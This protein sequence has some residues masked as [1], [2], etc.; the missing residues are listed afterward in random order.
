MSA[1]IPTG[2]CHPAQGCEERPTLGNRTTMNA[3]LKGLCRGRAYFRNPFRV[4]SV[5]DASSKVARSSQP[6]AEGWNPF[7]I[8]QMEFGGLP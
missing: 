2:L 3:T 7:G 5:Y 6:W 8:L 4:E 1:A